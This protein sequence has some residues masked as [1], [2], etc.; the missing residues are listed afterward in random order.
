MPACRLQIDST[1]DVAH[2]ELEEMDPMCSQ[3]FDRKAT[4][5]LFA[6]GPPRLRKTIENLSDAELD[7]SLGEGSW[8][9]REI[10]HHLADGDDIWKICVKRAIGNEGDLFSM[11][12]YGEKTQL[13]WSE[14]W[15]YSA[16]E[17]DSS[18]AFIES[19]RHHVIQLVEQVPGA[20][21]R[22]I[23]I[24][25]PGGDIEVVTVGWVIDMQAKH[26]DGHLAD[27]KKILATQG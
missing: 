16:R 12:W 1:E 15:N 9:I 21:D 3:H 26:I 17:V 19:S 7:L 10:I 2:L 4:L 13:E 20:W 11:E 25:W 22:S 27:I 6:D 14:S 23:R 24:R 5:A 8:S 18:L